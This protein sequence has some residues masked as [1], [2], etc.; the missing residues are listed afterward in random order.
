MN[1]GVEVYKSSREEFLS[2]TIKPSEWVVHYK[3]LII[4]LKKTKYS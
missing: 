4:I 3:N 1:R 2:N